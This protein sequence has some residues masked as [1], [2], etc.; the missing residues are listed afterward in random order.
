MDQKT[1]T[2]AEA[3]AQGLKRYFTGR[4]CKR[5]HIAERQTDNGVCVDCRRENDRRHYAE[6]MAA[7]GQVNKRKYANNIA[8]YREYGRQYSASNSKY[9]EYKA[10]YIQQ[11]RI[12]HAEE[13]AAYRKQYYE[14]HA[15]EYRDYSKQY[16]ER[17]ADK[18]REY[19]RQ[20]HADNAAVR[21]EYNRQWVAE[22]SDRRK[23]YMREYNQRYCTDNAV[24]LR[25][26][27]RQRYRHDPKAYVARA[28]ARKSHIKQAIPTWTKFSEIA[29]FYR[30]CPMGYH[31]DHIV[32][33]RGKQVSGLHC[34][35]N[36][37]YLPAKENLSK[38]NKFDPDT[39][40]HEIPHGNCI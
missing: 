28:R 23:D 20:W 25:E 32:P 26:S 36:L 11:Y 4:A 31:V 39:Y 1:I 16:R 13:I 30:R 37:Q 27:R 15:A 3:K 17:N 24:S 18:C 29:E 7:D 12:D 34:L 40:V 10:N 35:A 33:L 21:A 6:G 22:N 2:R 9:R 19:N 8:H 38:N 5:G 14:D